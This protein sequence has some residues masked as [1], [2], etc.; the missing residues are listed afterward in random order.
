MIT[1]T[2]RSATRFDRT[3]ACGHLL[4]LLLLGFISAACAAVSPSPVLMPPTAVLPDDLADHRWHVVRL[5]MAWAPDTE[6]RWFV[7][8]LLAN[9]VMAPVLRRHGSD[10]SLWRFHRRARRDDAGHQFSFIFYAPPDPA[11]AIGRAIEES[12][13]LL[14]LKDAGVVVSVST[15][16]WGGPDGGK[17]LS[18]T[19]DANWSASMQRAWPLYIEGVSRLWLALIEDAKDATGVSDAPDDMDTWLALYRDIDAAVIAVW[20]EEGR[21]ALLHHLNAIFGYEPIPVVERR[22]L[23]F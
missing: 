8:S 22:L 14:R 9:E 1:A 12:Q 15:G 5:R 19:S 6:P 20:Q 3:G 23:R 16:Q 11:M 2:G 21:H 10:V 17:A 4:A 7:D 18:A 13:S